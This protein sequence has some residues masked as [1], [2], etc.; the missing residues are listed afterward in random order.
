MRMAKT[1]TI[2]LALAAST[3]LAGAGEVRVLSVGSTQVGAKALAADFAKASGHTVNFT[4][5]PPFNIDEEFGKG[6]FDVLIL[7]VPAMETYDK[8]GNLAPQSRK[9]L[10]RVGVGVVVK[11]GAA[12][13]DVST[14]DKLKA[15]ILAARSITHGDPKLPNTSGAITAAAIDKLGI[16]EQ[17]KPKLKIAGLGPGG[18]MVAKGEI[19][20]G[21]YN[22]SEIP[23]GT[24]VAGP[25]P[26]PLQGYTV[27]EAAMT[28]KGSKDKAAADFVKFLA[29]GAGTW[30][31][32]RR[33]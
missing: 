26:A 20:M 16:G 31:A 29:D 28:S 6:T 15:A 30:Q 14:P 21:F 3:S 27:Y 7:S 2:A 10:A 33:G 4:I 13:P 23:H 11:D 32:A 25:L 5:R 24:A 9:P 8:A 1:A 19:E 18:E 22:L 12:K 17:I